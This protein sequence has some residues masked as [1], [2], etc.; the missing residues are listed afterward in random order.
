MGGAA[1]QG[2]EEDTC[3]PVGSQA[4]DSQVAAGHLER[5][6]PRQRPRLPRG[7]WIQGLRSQLRGGWVGKPG[8]KSMAEPGRGCRHPLHPIR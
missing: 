6:E 8:P 2:A 4:R 7:P 5:A 1:D 3:Q